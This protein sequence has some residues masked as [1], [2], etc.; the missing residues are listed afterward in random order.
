MS[1][2]YL[3]EHIGLR[4]KVALKV[5]GPELADD[6]AFRE[7]F[8][9]E[10][11]ITARLDHPNIVTVYDAGEADGVLYISMRYVEGTDLERLLR[12]ETRLEPGRAVSPDLAGC[13]GA[14]CRPCG[15]AG[16]SRREARE[17]PARVGC[18]LVVGPRVPLRL[19]RDEAVGDRRRHHT[20][21]TVRRD[22]RLRVPRA[23]PGR[24]RGRPRRR[25]LIGVRAVPVPDRR[26]SVPARYRGRDDLRASP[27]PAARAERALPRARRRLRRTDR[28]GA[29]EASRRPLRHVPWIS[30]MRREPSSI[31]TSGGRPARRRPARGAA[32]SDDVAATDRVRVG[33]TRG[34]GGRRDR[35][36]PALPPRRRRNGRPSTLAVAE[37]APAADVERGR[38]RARCSRR[39][40]DRGRRRRGRNDRRG[41]SRRRRG[42]PERGGVD[43]VGR[44]AVDAGVGHV[45]GNDRRAADG[46]R[47]DDGRRRRGG[48]LGADRGRPRRRGVAFGRPGHVLGPGG[49]C[50]QR[51]ARSGRSGDAG[52]GGGHTRC[53][54]GGVRHLSRR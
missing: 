44:Q 46:C 3:A 24:R 48:R 5:L 38:R 6:D 25:L 26:G 30:P 13:R 41:G 42:R 19:R 4:R 52:R 8:I 35:R 39:P 10:S 9:R 34:R 49:G 2:V 37:P 28:P 22:R 29:R 14:R 45:P 12:A 43:V 36:L 27:G 53:R 51:A 32:A 47:R 33:R 50:H 40:G 1:V 21:R 11:Q 31:R 54:R 7:R 20:H 15:R 23:D 17:H 18:A 16:P